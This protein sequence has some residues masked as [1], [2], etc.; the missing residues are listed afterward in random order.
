MSYG[1]A[2]D[3]SSLLSTDESRTSDT[4]NS[5]ID[6]ST[7]ANVIDIEALRPTQGILC[8]F[9]LKENIFHVIVVAS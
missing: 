3:P 2:E 1:D 5:S 4:A 8:L 7:T 6:N 9:C